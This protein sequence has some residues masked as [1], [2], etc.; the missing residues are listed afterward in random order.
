MNI[1]NTTQGIY[2]YSYLESNGFSNEI[3]ST[4]QAAK[5]VDAAAVV[6]KASFTFQ[7]RQNSRNQDGGG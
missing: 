5:V 2:Y 4:W 1:E 7:F 6:V 3:T